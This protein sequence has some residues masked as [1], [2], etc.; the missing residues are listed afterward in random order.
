MRWKTTGIRFYWD[1]RQWKSA[2]YCYKNDWKELEYFVITKNDHFGRIIVFRRIGVSL[3]IL[4]KWCCGFSLRNIWQYLINVVI[5][6]R[7][8][9]KIWKISAATRNLAKI[10][11]LSNGKGRRSIGMIW[12][13]YWGKM[14]NDY[15]SFYL[16][17]CMCLDV[18]VC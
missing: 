11:W 6:N 8:R 15:L 2:A 16:E 9:V 7:Q 3:W 12:I 17:V 5:L 18:A 13:V 14:M 10:Y 1:T 4:R